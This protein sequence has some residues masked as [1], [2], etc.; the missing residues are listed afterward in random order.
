M[1]SNLNSVLLEG[2]ILKKSKHGIIRVKGIS[3]I[4]FSVKSIRQ[5][6]DDAPEISI[7]EVEA[8]GKLAETCAVECIKDRGLRVVGRLR[9]EN[10]EVD[11]V[12]VSQTWIIAEHVEFKPL[13]VEKE[14]T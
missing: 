8:F 14:Q 3:S 7:F 10:D 11:G 6:I 5:Y 12:K 2:V 1:P 4:R 9:Q 13:S